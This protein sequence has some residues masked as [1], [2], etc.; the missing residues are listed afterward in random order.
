MP[1]AVFNEV[2]WRSP[3]SRQALSDFFADV[4][5][6]VGNAGLMNPVSRLIWK[7]LRIDGRPARY[8]SEPAT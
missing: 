6:L 7:M 3:E 1:R 2:Y 8:R 5:M 4:R